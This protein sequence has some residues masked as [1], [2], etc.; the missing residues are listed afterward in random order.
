VL[1]FD[2]LDNGVPA[3][4]VVD[5]ITV[6]GGVHDVQAQTDAVLLD[7][8]C[9]RVDFGGL[10]DGF[11]GGETAFAVDE[12]RGEDGVDEGGLAEAGLSCEGRGGS[13]YGPMAGRECVRGRM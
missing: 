10:A 13:V 11:V 7:Y 5:Q 6:A 3:A 2:V 4:V 9:D 1:V 12:M 8:V